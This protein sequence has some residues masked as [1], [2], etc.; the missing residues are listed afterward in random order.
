MLDSRPLTPEAKAAYDT[1]VA[2]DDV[3]EVL[4][5]WDN[6]ERH[7]V[8]KLKRCLENWRIYWAHDPELG[9]GQWP[10]DAVNFMLEQNRSLIQYNFTKVIVDTIAGGIMQLPFDPEFYPV[11]EQMTSLTQ[12]IKQAMYS[13]KELMDWKSAYM[14][15][16]RDG[17]IH[18]GVI[19]MVIS[20][21]WDDLGNIGFERCLPGSVLADPNWKTWGSKSCKKC[22]HEVWMTADQMAEVYPEKA[23]LIKYKLGRKG[24]TVSEEYGSYTGINPYLNEDSK[25]GD[26]YNVIEEYR[27]VDC[28]DKD[29]IAI[30]ADGEITIPDYLSDSEKPQWLNTFHPSWDPSLVYEKPVKVKKCF[31]RAVCRQFSMNETL[32]SNPIEIQIGRLPF[33]FWSAS[34]ANGEAHSIVDSVKDAQRQ[35]N[36]MSSLI[37]HKI[38]IEGGG[39]A[40]FVDREAFASEEEFQR[41]RNNRNDASETFEVA[42]GTLANGKSPT[43][44]VRTS[45]F[46]SE[47]YE[48]INHIVRVI[49]PNTSY[50]TP[51]TRGMAQSSSESGRLFEL[52]KIQSD[53]QVYT[54][55][56]GLR[57]F[58]NEVYE[59]YFMQA[60]NTY[61]AE[62]LPRKFATAGGKNA[63]TLNEKIVFPNGSVGI[64][65]DVRALKKIRHKVIIDEKQETP[66][67][68]AES[69]NNIGRFL[70]SIGDSSPLVSRYLIKKA[71]IMM[72]QTLDDE[73]REAIEQLANI[74]LALAVA[75]SEGQLMNAELQK[76][77]LGAQLEDTKL[78]MDQ[79]K[80]AQEQEQNGAQGFGAPSP[81]QEV[82]PEGEAVAEQQQPPSPEEMMSTIQQPQPAGQQPQAATFAGG[83]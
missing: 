20:N 56:Y 75:N 69:L 62:G 15:L 40:Q 43:A 14:E 67:E 13:D 11:N 30:T 48:S 38:Q 31:M 49:L 17:L 79:K 82:L 2:I 34:R 25:W 70:K 37:S 3:G 6:A 58:W 76:L 7:Y 19:K 24:G 72:N 35:I 1:Y 21:E 9:L 16:V 27:M 18:E 81:E 5:G 32:E 26:A 51:A 10:E 12:A 77:N 33:F 39:G 63:I 66:T 42:P 46:P 55:H 65:N 29:E 53:Q 74:D 8:R 71:S 68:K 47:A 44:P 22:W 73:D 23:E 4:R 59:A 41:Y 54:I 45:N 64:K 83:Q 36:Y 80:K 60:A 61:G 57:M 52:M 78:A 28:V 50:V